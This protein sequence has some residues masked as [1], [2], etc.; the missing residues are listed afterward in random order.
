MSESDLDL[1]SV[2]SVHSTVECCFLHEL[3]FPWR[4]LP[5]GVPVEFT[6]LAEA[7]SGATAY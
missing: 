1:L 4:G 6:A 2:S 7:F 5:A 3:R